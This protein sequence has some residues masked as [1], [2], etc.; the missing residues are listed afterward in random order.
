MVRRH[1][2]GESQNSSILVRY[3]ESMLVVSVMLARR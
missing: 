1:L 2:V 3:S